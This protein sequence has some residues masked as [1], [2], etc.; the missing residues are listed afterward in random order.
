[1]DPALKALT[2]LG[3]KD[4]TWLLQQNPN[5][6]TLQVLGARDPETLVKFIKQYQLH[7]DTAWY[8]TELSGKPWYVLVYRFYTDK[9]IARQSIQ[10]LPEGIR[11]SSPWVKS[12]AAVQKSIKP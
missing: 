3:I 2:E 5:Y 11:K 12:V 6:W 7:D 4:K 10:R 1:M 9:D 8:Q